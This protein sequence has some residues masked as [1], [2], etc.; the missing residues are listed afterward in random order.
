[1]SAPNLPLRRRLAEM[2]AERLRRKHPGSTV[3]IIDPLDPERPRN[4]T[5]KANGPRRPRGPA[6]P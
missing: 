4:A 6:K 1:M 2:L 3:E 5:R